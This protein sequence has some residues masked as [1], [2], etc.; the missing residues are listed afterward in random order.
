LSRLSPSLFSP[1]PAGALC[2]PVRG[3]GK[4]LRRGERGFT[5]VELLVV[6]V[7]LGLLAGLVAPR[8]LDYLGGARKDTVQ[9]QMKNLADILD[10]YYLENHSYPSTSQGLEA[11][12][13]CPPACTDGTRPMLSN[14]PRDPWK[15]AYIYRSPGQSGPFDLCSSGPGGD[16]QSGGA[17]AVICYQ[18]P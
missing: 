8:V 6:L 9:L 12:T 14:V 10:L 4:R 5:L 1:L 16:A 2:F 17:S 11:L 13:R 15:H 3:K 18:P 7:I